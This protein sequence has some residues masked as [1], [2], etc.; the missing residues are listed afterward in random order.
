M[1]V[2]RRILN[3]FSPSK[4]A[5]EIDAEIRSHIEMRVADNIANGMAPEEARRNAVRR[6]GNPALTK[7]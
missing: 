2:V 3:L 4:L 6:F 1:S 7:Q 5:E